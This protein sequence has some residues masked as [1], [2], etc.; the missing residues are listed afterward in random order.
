MVV[1]IV[2]TEATERN[3]IIKRVSLIRICELRLLYDMVD[4][5]TSV[6]REDV[7][8]IPMLFLSHSAV[9]T[10][11]VIS[12]LSLTSPASPERRVLSYD[13]VWLKI[14]SRYNPTRQ[15]VLLDP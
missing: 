4:M 10:R 8:S 2:V 3:K 1:S 9:T 12:L 11:P 15:T 14:L 13:I 5:E 7:V 6:R